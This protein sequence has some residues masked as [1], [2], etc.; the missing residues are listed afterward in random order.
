MPKKKVIR[1]SIEILNTE[2]ESYD[3][4]VILAYSCFVLKQM[5]IVSGF[6]TNF[7]KVQPMGFVPSVV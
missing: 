7:T 3:F 4:L 6:V 2:V 1:K 5:S